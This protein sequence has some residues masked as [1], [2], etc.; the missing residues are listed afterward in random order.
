[1][2]VRGR[3]VIGGR[4]WR[5]VEVSEEGLPKNVTGRMRMLA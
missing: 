3:Y 4:K 2:A 1:M 5:G